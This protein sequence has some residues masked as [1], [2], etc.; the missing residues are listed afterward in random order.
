MSNNLAVVGF[1]Y[2]KDSE[3]LIEAIEQQM[4]QGRQLKGEYYLA[5]AINIMLEKGMQMRTQQV[6]VWLDAG[7]PEAV[8]ETNRYLLKH[9]HDNSDE[10]TWIENT[11]MIPPVFVHPNAEV[12]ASVLG[13]YVSIGPGCT[14]RQSVMR[15]TIIEKGS[16]VSGASLNDSLI[17]ENAVIEGNT[18]RINVGDNSEVKI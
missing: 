14:V 17:G 11:T 13:P 15:D 2:F 12:E 1:Y 10:V 8:L 3:G 18:S 5:D 9:G 7:T 4:Q 16:Q 6:Q